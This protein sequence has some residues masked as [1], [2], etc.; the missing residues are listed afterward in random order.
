[1]KKGDYQYERI[2]GTALILIGIVL[3]A[4]VF[5]SGFAILGDPG[6][7]YDEW[8]P[9]EQAAG[10]EASFD[11]TA[12]GLLVEFTDTSEIGDAGIERWVWDF[13][14]GAESNDQ[15]PT[16][17][18]TEQGELDVALDVVDENGLSS[19]AESTVEVEPGATNRGDGAIGLSD[20]A[21]TVVDTVERAS[22]G[23]MV[24]LLVIGLFV[25]LTMIGGRLVRQGVRMLRPVPDRI[26]MKL[27]PK[28]LHL[29]MLESESDTGG[30]VE[31]VSTPPSPLDYDVLDADEPVE[32]GV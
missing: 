7:Y 9:D 29:A 10:P 1:M 12:S 8:V 19:R 18:F 27:R 25:V 26:N 13:G 14:D 3:L 11:W 5:L 2:W 22:K 4:V 16:H 20:I 31:G 32:A 21:D 30:A 17:R 23:G 15:N 24:V 28:E 6:E